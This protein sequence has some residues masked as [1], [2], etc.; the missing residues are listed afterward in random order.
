MTPAGVALWSTQAW[1]TDATAWVDAQLADGRLRRA[2]ATV[3]ETDPSRGRRWCARR[4]RRPG[5]VEGR[6][7]RIRRSRSALYDV[8]AR[9][10]PEH[11]LM[12]IAVTST[13]PGCCCRTAASRSASDWR[14]DAGGRLRRRARRVRPPPARGR[15]ARPLTAGRRRRGHAARG[16]ARAVRRG[17]DGRRGRRALRGARGRGDA[18]VFGVV[19]AARGSALP[20]TLD[21][22]DLHP[23]NVVGDEEASVYDWGDDVHATRSPRHARAARRRAAPARCELD[24]PGSSASA[25]RTS[26]GSPSSARAR[27]SRPRSRSRAGS[28]RSPAC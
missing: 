4:P 11:V 22:N 20:A 12:P 15:A 21:H 27:S 3:E 24:D 8:L 6:R 28:R 13:A 17:A 16:D 18:G 10:V 25:T 7:S 5:V 19:R 14:A 1:R 9:S 23:W 26:T 2:R